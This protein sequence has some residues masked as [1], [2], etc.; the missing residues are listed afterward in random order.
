M[1]AL[2]GEKI[3]A[4]RRWLFIKLQKVWPTVRNEIDKKEELV[5]FTSNSPGWITLVRTCQ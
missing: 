5:K 1:E 4:P 3:K 2:T